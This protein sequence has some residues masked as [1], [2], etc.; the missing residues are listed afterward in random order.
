LGAGGTYAQ[1]R[2]ADGAHLL[3]HVRGTYSA[4]ENA[5][6]DFGR[7]VQPILQQHCY[8]CHGPTQQTALIACGADVNAKSLAGQ[9]ALG[10]AK[11]QRH[12]AVVDLLLK[13][14]PLAPCWQSSALMAG[15]RSCRRSRATRTRR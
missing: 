10:Y 11:Q 1:G 9:T 3:R 7:D 13:R 6:V 12:T 4:Q 14:E 15:G 2:V 8:T 5:K